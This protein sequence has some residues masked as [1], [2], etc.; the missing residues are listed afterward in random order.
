MGD[1]NQKTG[2]NEK[3]LQ[4]V[5]RFRQSRNTSVLTIMFTDIEGFTRLTEERGDAYSDAVRKT[6][7]G[8]LVPVIESGGGGRVIKHIGDSV[9]AVF[10]E[11]STA[12]ARAMEIQSLLKKHSDSHPDEPPILVRIGLHMGQVTVEDKMSLDVFGRHVNRASRVEALAA[13]GHIYLT[14]TVFD[15]A[16][17]WLTGRSQEAAWLSHGRY[18]VRGIDEALEI[19]EVYAPGKVA[20]R[21]P[22]GVKKVSNGPGFWLP[23]TLLFLAVSLSVG[24]WLTVFSPMAK[25]SPNPVAVPTVASTVKFE[26]LDFGSDVDLILDHKSPLSIE[27]TRQDTF[28]KSL[29]PFGPGV[30]LIHYDVSPVSRYYSVIKVVPGENLVRLKFEEFDLPRLRANALYQPGEKNE[31]SFS[32]NCD[33]SSLSDAGVKKSHTGWIFLNLKAAPGTGRDELV[34]NINWRIV[35]DGVQLSTGQMNAAID[36]S[37]REAVRGEKKRLWEDTRHAYFIKYHLLAGTSAQVEIDAE[38]KAVK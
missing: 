11:P 30:H 20:P 28:R 24:L 4:Q 15:S 34:W 38:Y 16:K 29:T 9:M 10:A 25:K 1:D 26:K 35:R 5:D 3:E 32:N 33:Y 14:Y 2:I 37:S 36:M 22:V 13:G 8:L 19:F 12:V 6:H 31:F 21:P 17:G 23:A 7:D 27:G 18:K